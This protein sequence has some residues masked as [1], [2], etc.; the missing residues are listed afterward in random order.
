[1][2]EP[3]VLLGIALLVLQITPLPAD[4]LHRLSPELTRLIVP[5]TDSAAISSP[6][7]HTLSIFPAATR[8]ALVNVVAYVLLFLVAAQRVR[9]VTDARRV[10]N[11]VALATFGMA[12]FG[13]VHFFFSNGKFFWYLPVEHVDASQVAHG[14]FVNR[15]H[16]AQFLALGV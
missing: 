5:A 3:L 11:W 12:T 7:W 2:I 14:S 1:G 15:N 6:D 13:L 16:L 8:H 10:L 4:W 9:S